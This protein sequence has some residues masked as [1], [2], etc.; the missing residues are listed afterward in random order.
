VPHALRKVHPD[1]PVVHERPVHVK[2]GPLGRLLGLEAD[3]RV[4]EGVAR[5]A[6]PRD[7]A[8]RHRTEPREDG[9][10]VVA[11]RGRVELAHE[12]DGV[13]RG[14]VGGGEVADHLEDDGALARLA[15]GGGLGVVVVAAIAVAVGA[16]R[17]S[18]WRAP[19]V[20]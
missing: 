11:R 8:L 13:G 1:A 20:L 12:E 17:S 3:E 7:V 16:V 14:G 6:V 5:A 9:S 15:T 4:P 10:Q 19:V 18:A 2:V